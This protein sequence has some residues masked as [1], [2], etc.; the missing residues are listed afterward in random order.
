MACL[1]NKS[2]EKKVNCPRESRVPKKE[3]IP[4]K[5]GIWHDEQDSKQNLKFKG[6]WQL[7]LTQNSSLSLPI[8]RKK[9]KTK[10][11][12]VAAERHSIPSG[13]GGV[14][15]GQ[16]W[17]QRPTSICE[18]PPRDPRRRKQSE[19][20]LGS[21]VSFCLKV[22]GGGYPVSKNLDLHIN[23]TIFIPSGCCRLLKHNFS[24]FKY[25]FLKSYSYPF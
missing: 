23:G 13:V 9:G 10:Q 19:E 24:T 3:I 22:N 18:P 1:A 2:D 25:L 8:Y 15:C 21:G 17:G 12:G 6:K 11:P 4:N 5:E 14:K 7:W 20:T 16:E